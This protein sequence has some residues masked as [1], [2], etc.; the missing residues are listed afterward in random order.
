MAEPARSIAG[1]EPG[2]ADFDELVSVSRAVGDALRANVLRV[3]KDE[4]YA[5]SELCRILDTAQPA[6]SHH[7]KVLHQA[8]LVVKR[9][10]GNVIFYR[11][12]PAPAPLHE[13]LLAAIDRVVLPASQQQHI[14][15][16]HEERSRRSEAFF[17]EHAED[18]AR[19]QARISDATVY[20]ASVMDIVD[21]HALGAG[22]ALDIGPGDGELLEPLARRFRRVVGID[23]TPKMLAR[24]AARASSLG[25]VRL[26]HRDFAR[27][28]AQRRYQLVVAAMVVHHLPSPQQFFHHAA[29]LLVHEGLLIVVELARHDHE[30][31]RSACGDLWLGFEP[32]ELTE[33][34][35]KAGLCAEESQFLAQKNGFRIQIHT[36][37]N[38]R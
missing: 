7:L 32:A 23:S 33:W 20:A 15:Q 37:Q 12:A 19:N 25:N 5:V 38:P 8:R 18:F 31:A 14:D 30:W 22:T 29:R 3:L 24:S 35:G 4:S 10:D 27:L 17:A 2:T 11:R 9:R 26:M 6:L 16:V 21:R 13:A 34:A 1:R 36:Y 28:P